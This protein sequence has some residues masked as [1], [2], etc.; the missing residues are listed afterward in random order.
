MT[1]GRSVVA[2]STGALSLARQARPQNLS[3]LRS[4]ESL[5]QT[6][7]NS[8]YENSAAEQGTEE[9]RPY[10]SLGGRSDMGGERPPVA[11]T[12]VV[13]VGNL[14]Y[15]CTEKDLEEKFSEFGDV[16]GVKIPR[17]GETGVARGYVIMLLFL[18]FH[19]ES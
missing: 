19:E 7:W 1:A 15:E 12:K 18:A 3:E 17:T 9:R 8:S 11:P 16:R 14:K 6:R 13:Y 4:F 2:P 10:R 5:L